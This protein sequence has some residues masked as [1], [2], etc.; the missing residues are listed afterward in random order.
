MHTKKK[1]RIS[2]C[3]IVRN[4]EKNIRRALSWGKDRMWE[5]IVV[6]TGSTDRT[7][8]IAEEMG[9]KVFF[10]QWKDDF[11][12]AKNYAIDQAKGDWIAFL[13]ADEYM[14]PDIAEKLQ[15]AIEITDGKK[16]D[17]I[18]TGLQNL[19]DQGEIFSCWSQVRVFRNH[20]DIRYRRRIHE[21]LAS[22]SGRR[23]RIEGMVSE[24][25]FYHTGYQEKQMEVKKRSR[26]NRKM[27]LEEL[28]EHP[29]DCEMMGYM[30]DDCYSHQ[31][32]EEAKAWYL[33][34]VQA[35]PY[36][37][38]KIDLRSSLTFTNLLSIMTDDLIERRKTLSEQECQACLDEIY[39]IYEKAVTL[40]PEDADFDYVMGLFFAAVGQTEGGARHLEAS[41]Q[42]LETYG[43]DG[44]AVFVSSN[45]L[46]AYH[47]LVLCCY[48]L[49]EAQKCAVYATSYLQ[50]DKYGMEELARLLKILVPRDSQDIRQNQ[51][52][53]LYFSKL[54]DFSSLKDLLFLIKAAEGSGCKNFASFLTN[55]FFTKEQQ[56]QLRLT[57]HFDEK[58]EKT[59]KSETEVD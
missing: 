32:E 35:M 58:K 22:V 36:P 48:E 11:A 2:Q 54:Y 7:V 40:L 19:N 24:L 9:A 31:E 41:V 38:E 59:V 57:Q 56:I 52:L 20:P 39:K 6:D 30:G 44:K 18:L 1:I 43:C 26:R 5:Q 17:G 10:F 53:L 8:E 16:M 51:E 47:V 33:K 29:D 34:S 3:M 13:D 25:S 45:R 37:L 49:G 28:K 15:I 42:K 14:T 46:K 21:Y 50:Y 12:A 27:I 4:E 23:L 55:Q